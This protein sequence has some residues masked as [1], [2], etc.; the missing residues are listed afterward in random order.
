MPR[1]VKKVPRK[2]SPEEQIGC[3]QSPD[4]QLSQVTLQGLLQFMLLN[5]TR[6]SCTETKAALGPS[7]V[8]YVK[9]EK[10]LSY[11]DPAQLFSFMSHH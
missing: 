5:I 10:S 8:S 9:Y 1:R 11:L 7:C 6:N 3:L 2:T 4:I